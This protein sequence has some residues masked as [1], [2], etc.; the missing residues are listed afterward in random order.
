[1]EDKPI[2][3]GTGHLIDGHY[4]SWD[5]ETKAVWN[6]TS[7]AM[8]ENGSIKVDLIL[9]YLSDN[10]TGST[11]YNTTTYGSES[12]PTSGELRYLTS[13]VLAR[14][15]AEYYAKQLG[16]G[17]TPS[18]SEVIA[19]HA[20]NIDNHTSFASFR[21]NYNTSE[22]YLPPIPPIYEL[23]GYEVQLSW[24]RIFADDSG[25]RYYQ[26]LQGK[27][28]YAE[29]FTNVAEINKEY[30]SLSGSFEVYK[31]I[32]ERAASS[33]GQDM[34]F[35]YE[36]WISENVELERTG[37]SSG[38]QSLISVETEESYYQ[39][40]DTIIIT[41]HVSPNILKE[42]VPLFIQVINPFGAMARDDF[43]YINNSDGT[44][45]YELPT[46]GQLT[47][48]S[49][50]Y[51]VLVSYPEGEYRAETTYGFRGGDMA[52]DYQCERI[53]CIH[54]LTVSNVNYTI[55]HKMAGWISNVT[56]LPDRNSLTIEA[57]TYEKNAPLD[58]ALPRSLIES[59]GTDKDGNPVDTPF[60]VLVDG[61]ET[62][63]EET[64][65][66]LLGMDLANE[67]Y[68]TLN[69]P[70]GGAHSKIEIIGTHVAPEFGSSTLIAAIGVATIV[71]IIVTIGRYRIGKR[72]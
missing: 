15:R 65:I 71:G 27:S 41:G 47:G 67:R 62:A 1:M 25:T 4:V 56:A 44:F 51:R 54:K 29:G 20:R 8:Y 14:V 42:D 33:L 10:P 50:E 72:N 64:T 11:I 38:S 46:G 31:P 17:T 3:V 60:V 9:E 68:R 49:G 35:D 30:T 18:L 69:I 36:M 43:I 34:N 70:Y 37:D 21:S 2:L 40:P 58:I 61:E 48:I 53:F 23:R 6:A 63:H 45:K 13:I 28:P 12:V 66:E 19:V 52:V 5:N 59:V 16:T 7:F 24:V 32:P 26:W 22:E 57:R 39:I 55:A